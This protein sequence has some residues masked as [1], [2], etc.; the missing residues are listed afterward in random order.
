V[1][2][3]RRCVVRGQ[4]SVVSRRLQVDE[5]RLPVN[6]TRESV[7]VMVRYLTMTGEAVRPEVSKDELDSFSLL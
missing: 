2:S 5:K 6:K 7:P 4:W 1:N 3:E